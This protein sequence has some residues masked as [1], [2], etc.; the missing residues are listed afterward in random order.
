MKSD[1]SNDQGSEKHE[2]EGTGHEKHESLF[3]VS[4]NE[5]PVNLLGHMETGVEIKTAAIEQN[6]DIQLDF[7]LEEELPD[8]ARRI[9]EDHEKVHLREGLRFTAREHTVTVSVNELPVILPGHT[10]TGAEIETAAIAQGV[11]IQMNFVLQEEL[12]NGTSR[13][14]GPSDRVHLREHLA[15]HGDCAG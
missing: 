1:E 3:T 2:G 9:V 7:V 6:V 15:F 12:P 13:M 11:H 4:V 5:H 14:V 8:G 10:A